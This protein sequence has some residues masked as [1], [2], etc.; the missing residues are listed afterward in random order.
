MLDLVIL[1][2]TTH[3]FRDRERILLLTETPP[4]FGWSLRFPHILHQ[5]GLS[6][7]G[8]VCN[9][10]VRVPKGVKYHRVNSYRY[11][12]GVDRA[13]WGYNILKPTPPPP[14]VERDLAWSMINML[15]KATT[16]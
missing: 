7:M 1:P 13:G 16:E 10:S 6:F 11:I 12:A 4:T 5:N 3:P 2:L 9:G 8:G 14:R 15:R